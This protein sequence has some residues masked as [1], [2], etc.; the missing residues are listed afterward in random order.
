MMMAMQALVDT[1]T[2]WGAYE[3]AIDQVDDD[4]RAV[5]LADQAVADAQ[6]SG[7][8]KDL[9]SL[10]RQTGAIRLLTGFM[11][12][13]NTTLNVNYRVLKSD[14]SLGKKVVDLML[15][16]AIPTILMIVLKAALTPGDSG[17]DEPEEIAKKYAIEQTAFLLGQMVGLREIGQI[18]AAALG[19]KSGDYG[20]AVGLRMF[21]DILKL[22]KQ[23]GQGEMDDSLRKAVIN[24]AGDTLRIPSAQINRTITGAKA[25][26]EDETDNPAALVFGFQKDR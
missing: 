1:P 7:M 10:E 22:A 12:F 18:G 3:K 15:V 6:G 21:G 2:W 11:S 24:A 14:R 8:L 19:E 20:G 16:N 13:M 26:A 9:S 23:V 4:A 5:A 17:D 25:L